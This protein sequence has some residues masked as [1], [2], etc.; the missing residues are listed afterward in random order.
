MGVLSVILLILFVIVAVLLI[1]LIA[2]Q[3]ENSQGLGGI[4][5]GS[6]DSVLGTGA[7]SFLNKVTTG[8][9]IAFMV[10]ALLVAFVNKS[11]TSDTLLD[12]AAA[13]NSN[14][15]WYAQDA[16]QTTTTTK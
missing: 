12:S 3:D 11:N 15:N 4:F 16:S 1:F 14:S 7:S 13:Q 6:S 9:A 5:G 2:V 10:L 8:C